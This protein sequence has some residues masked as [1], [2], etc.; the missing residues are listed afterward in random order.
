MYSAL[1][2][3]YDNESPQIS[4]QVPIYCK[5]HRSYD[6]LRYP[7]LL[8]H[9]FAR[10]NFMRYDDTGTVLY[11]NMAENY[12]YT[13]KGLKENGILPVLSSWSSSVEVMS[14]FPAAFFPIKI[15]TVLMFTV[16]KW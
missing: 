10:I 4:Q 14:K 5:L 9:A 1:N 6:T 7:T 2:E 12:G 13:T 3:P 11:W 15:Q 16:Q 8:F